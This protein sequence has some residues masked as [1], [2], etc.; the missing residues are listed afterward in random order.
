MRPEDSPAIE[1]NAALMEKHRPD[2]RK[3]YYD[4]SRYKTYLE[5]LGIQYP[6]L[7]PARSPAEA[8]GP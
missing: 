8:A 5:Q 1:L 6:T 3:F 4:P 7:R 2:M